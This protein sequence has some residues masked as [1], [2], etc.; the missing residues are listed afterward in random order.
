[1]AFAGFHWIFRAFSLT[2]IYKRT[3]KMMLKN[4]WIFV[5]REG[6]GPVAAA[7]VAAD[8]IRGFESENFQNTSRHREF[9]GCAPRLETAFF[10]RDEGRYGTKLIDILEL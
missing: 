1:M 7:R 5:K 9:S 2:G 4:V 3:V 6:C 8:G 10:M